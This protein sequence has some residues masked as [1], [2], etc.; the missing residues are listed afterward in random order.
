MV[1]EAGGRWR[2][3]ALGLGVIAVLGASVVCSRRRAQ[4][5]RIG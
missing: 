5:A 4:P 3:V 1:S 2:R